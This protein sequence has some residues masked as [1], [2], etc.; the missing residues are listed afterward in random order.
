MTIT[1]DVACSDIA[2]DNAWV[3]LD[4]ARGSTVK[5]SAPHF[6]ELIHCAGLKQPPPWSRIGRKVAHVERDEFRLFMVRHG[7][8]H[9]HGDTP[10]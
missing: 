10:I 8:Q 7:E 2:W 5:L 6:L 3:A 4:T 1:A 9:G